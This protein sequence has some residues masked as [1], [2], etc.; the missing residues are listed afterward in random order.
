MRGDLF[1]GSSV[2]LDAMLVVVNE[3]G[4]TIDVVYI[5][6][7]TVIVLLFSILVIKNMGRVIHIM[8]SFRLIRV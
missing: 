5:K 3:Y 8:K 7:L 2:D 4:R 1:G 6:S